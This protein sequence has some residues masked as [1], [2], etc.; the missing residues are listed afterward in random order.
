MDVDRALTV[1][2]EAVSTICDSPLSDVEIHLLTGAWQGQTYDQIASAYGYSANYLRC[3]VG[4][5][6][7]KRLSQALGEPVNKTNFRAAIE[8]YSRKW[9]TEKRDIEQSDAIATSAAIQKSEHLT[10]WGEAIDIRSFN[11]RLEELHLL[12]QWVLQDRCR[13]VTLLGMGGIGKTALS[14]KL[15]HLL[16]SEFACVVW[17]SLRNAPPLKA[18]LQDLI[19]ILSNQQDTETSLNQLIYWLR[20][21]RCLIVLD[22]AET[23]LQTGEQ[24][25]SY[26]PGYENYGELLQVVGETAHQSC[27]IL[28]SREKPAEVAMLEGSELTVRSLQLSGSLEAAQGVLA[29]KQL[30][31]T[32]AEK[33]E[34][35]DRY[36]C[37]PLALKIVAS[38]IQDLFD[39]E[40]GL[41]LAEETIF[42]NGIR[43]LLDQQFD[44]L[45]ELE[46]RMMY[47]LASNR[48]WTS[49]AE[50]TVD[51]IPAVS[52]AELLGAL[53]SLNWRSLIEIAPRSLIEKQA[54]RYTQ[55]PVVM[56]YVTE[57]LIQ[58]ITRE[59]ETGT[60]DLFLK[61]ALIKTT[62]KD[63]VRNSQIRLILD[64]IAQQF[65]QR[66]N[67]A[68]RLAIQTRL[69]LQNIKL[70]SLPNNYGAGNLLNLCCHLSLDLSGYDFSQ[71]GVRHAYLVEAALRHINFQSAAFVQ[72]LFTQAFHNICAIAFSP[73]S[74]FMVAGDGNGQVLLWNA[75]THELMR[76]Y[77]GH[78]GWV[79]DVTV[80]PDSR[81]IVSGSSD[82]TI[83]LWD[84]E[85]GQLLRV[86]TEH[87]GPIRGVVISPDGR[88]LAS[89]SAD[90]TIKIWDMATGTLLHTLLG[91]TNW[92]RSVA[93][94]PDGQW[95]VSSSFDHTL[96]L[97][98][99]ASWQLQH[100]LEGHTNIVTGVA[101]SPDGELIASGSDDQTVRLWSQRTGQLLKVLKGHTHW[102]YT[103]A[104]SPNGRVLASG[105]ADET[106]KLWETETG[107]LLQ[108]LQ[109]HTNSIRAITYAPRANDSSVDV[110]VS[111]GEDQ[112]IR[113]W[114][115]ADGTLLKTLQG[116]TD[117]PM[118]TFLDP[119]G[120]W[121]VSSNI[122]HVVFIRDAATGQTLQSFKGHTNWVLAIA[123]SPDRQVLATGSDDFS[124][125]LWNIK[126]GQ[127]LKTL[128][129][130]TEALRFVTFSPDG[131]FLATASADQLALIWDV[132]TGELV[133]RFDQHTGWVESIAYAPNHSS[134][135]THS[136]FAALAQQIQ[137]QVIATSSTDRTIKL[138]DAVTGTILMTLTGHQSWVQ[139]LDFSPDG[140]YLA[141]GGVD[142]IVTLW[143]L[144]TGTILHT[145]QGHL[146]MVLW[147]RFS[148]DGTIL[149]SSGQDCIVRL[150]D[151]ATGEAI[152]T[153][154]GHYHSV[155]AVAFQADGKTIVTV[156]KD[157][158]VRFWDIET[159]HCLRIVKPERPYEGMNITGAIG[160]TDAQKETLKALGAIEH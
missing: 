88:H 92:V 134:F 68:Q 160:L 115:T 144:A 10:D 149:A 119:L 116:R 126:T 44:R 150:W 57:R 94:S 79:W 28:T 45:S 58:H 120:Q 146:R 97:W 31:G 112:T 86:L 51:L 137:P 21:R 36:G 6:F 89:A 132:A 104:F 75:A 30:I 12:K 59:L 54:G 7:W 157:E 108:T 117:T 87:T 110:L 127:L 156:G 93:F 63:Y 48:E 50:L 46:Q 100:I 77:I 107:Q 56:E 32:D 151:V 72:T 61:Q 70:T 18:L 1:T 155:F 5:K 121:S 11:G 71:L 142:Y 113:F 118:R 154:E 106:I 2:N 66:F 8:R 16:E 40:V 84:I 95:L 99:V 80:S 131:C 41:F 138:W 76:V 55:Q 42:F 29:E 33:Q 24:V 101:F 141:S 19:L 103:V 140:K 9:G 22:N 3:D 91:H 85:T 136:S 81:I 62:V 38:S 130:H 82:N 27:L 35:C 129:H 98:K 69:L 147:V 96:R 47:W 52:K 4:N 111:G 73:N 78:T 39:G 90:Y 139:T 83:R 152:A 102:L 14:V 67:T 34:L 135:Q 53:E 49:I 145:L 105:G 23:L 114:D 153:L 128:N 122:H 65:K 125:C 15:A 43:R 123:F 148:P 159:G 60:L 74:R 109:G 17:R 124:V 158:E 64:P 20:T 133:R 37:S 25:G 26:R 13:L 143:D